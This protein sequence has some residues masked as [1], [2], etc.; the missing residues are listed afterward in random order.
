M[1]K[2]KKYKVFASKVFYFAVEM[3][4]ILFCP[5]TPFTVQCL[6]HKQCSTEYF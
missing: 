2:F 3:I 4:N 6:D 5:V 1:Y